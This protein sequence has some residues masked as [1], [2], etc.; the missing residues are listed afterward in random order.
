MKVAGVRS[1]RMTVCLRWEQG[2][3][4]ELLRVSAISAAPR[5][6]FR[7]FAVREDA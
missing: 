7:P 1:L 2:D 4:D 6:A 5:E 3:A